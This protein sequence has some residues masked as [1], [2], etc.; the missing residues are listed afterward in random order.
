[1]KVKVNKKDLLR[2]I[3][4][5]D[6]FTRWNDSSW[7]ARKRLLD[8]VYEDSDDYDCGVPGCRDPHPDGEWIQRDLKDFCAIPAC[9]CPGDR[10]HS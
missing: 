5:A 3:T 8:A 1:M 7:K 10:S 2:L 4:E 9:G 6:R